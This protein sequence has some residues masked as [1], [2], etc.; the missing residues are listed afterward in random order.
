MVTPTLNLNR[1]WVV[2]AV[3]MVMVMVMTPLVMLQV[4]IPGLNTSIKL[5]LLLLISC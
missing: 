1:I 5:R 4:I 3:A 2:M